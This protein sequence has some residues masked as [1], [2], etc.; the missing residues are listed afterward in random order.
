M[1]LEPNRA[2]ALEGVRRLWYRLDKYFDAGTERA[3]TPSE[4]LAHPAPGLSP[5]DSHTMAALDI[6][7]FSA[8]QSR[9]SAR[10]ARH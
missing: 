8:S 1:M 10:S 2:F 6:S 9:S 4:L 7:W 3:L 5:K